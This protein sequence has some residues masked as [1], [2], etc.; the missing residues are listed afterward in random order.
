[1]WSGV[2]E[3]N[4]IFCLVS[5]TCLYNSQI[6]SPSPGLPKAVNGSQSTRSD[7]FRIYPYPPSRNNA[8]FACW[9]QVFERVDKVKQSVFVSA[10]SCVWIERRCFRSHPR[11]KLIKGSPVSESRI[12]GESAVQRESII[13]SKHRRNYIHPLRLDGGFDRTKFLSL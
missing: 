13:P 5:E 12:C 1:M 11:T 4:I 2:R 7:V 6:P 10:W 9:S 3:V 8:S